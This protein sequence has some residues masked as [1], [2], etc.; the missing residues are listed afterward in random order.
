M[1]LIGLRSGALGNATM[2]AAMGGLGGVMG[3]AMW[4]G[5]PHIM[6]WGWRYNAMLKVREEVKGREEEGCVK[7]GVVR[8]TM[9][10]LRKGEQAM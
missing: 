6:G 2:G 5:I 10:V 1:S 3:A 9:R 8:R 7:D 4:L